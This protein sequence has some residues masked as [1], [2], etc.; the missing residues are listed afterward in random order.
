MKIQIILIIKV[1]TCLLQWNLV[2]SSSRH[3]ANNETQVKSLILS[4]AENDITSSTIDAWS[5]Q[6]F[7]WKY[8]FVFKLH[9]QNNIKQ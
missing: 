1:Q 9:F 5:T 3:I 6:I 2:V 7:I 4:N 8:L